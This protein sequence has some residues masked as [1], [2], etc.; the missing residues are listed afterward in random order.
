MTCDSRITIVIPTTNNYLAVLH[1][2]SHLDCPI[3]SLTWTGRRDD[4]F[5]TMHLSLFAEK[6]AVLPVA[7]WT[8]KSVV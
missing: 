5:L 6:H 7:V 4:V 1:C 8:Q 2:Y 3:K